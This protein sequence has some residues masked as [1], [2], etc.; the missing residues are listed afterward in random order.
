MGQSVNKMRLLKMWCVGNKCSGENKEE[1][2]QLT[3]AGGGACLT[4][5]QTFRQRPHGGLG[6][7]LSGKGSSRAWPE[8]ECVPH[9]GGTQGHMAG[10]GL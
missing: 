7:C 5:K 2:R 3:G 1:E 8:G 4:E 10:R 9:A 6:K